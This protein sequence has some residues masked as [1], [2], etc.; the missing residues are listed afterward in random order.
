MRFVMMAYNLMSLHKQVVM[1]TPIQQ[2]LQTLRF[3]CFAVGS[4]IVKKGNTKILK[5]SI[6][7]EKRQW[8]DGLLKNA[9]DIDL[10]ISL[11]TG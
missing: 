4:W 1:K 6:K 11:R 3:N 7:M 9:R 8:M 2:R 5:L 10:P